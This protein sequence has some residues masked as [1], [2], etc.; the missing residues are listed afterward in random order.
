M[1][2]LRT[3]MA[4]AAE[5]EEQ[6]AKWLIRLDAGATPEDWARHARWL[7]DSPRHRAAFLRLSRAWSGSNALRKL[8][9]LDCHVD[10]DL[11]APAES[12]RPRV[13]VDWRRVGLAVGASVTLAVV[14]VFAWRN[15]AA[16]DA[17][18]YETKFAT[19]QHVSL[20][21][22]TQ[23]NLNGDSVIRVNFTPTLRD[24]VVERGE[25]LFDV[26]AEARR[27]FRVT[28]GNTV[29]TT[30]TSRFSV[31]RRAA[32]TTEVLVSRGQVVFERAR[33][34]LYFTGS[35]SRFVRTL[36]AG[37]MAS[38][39]NGGIFVRAIGTAAVHRRLAWVD[40][41]VAFLGETLEEAVRE[42]NRY[43]HQQ[44]VILDPAIGQLRVSGRFD[45]TDPDSFVASL[46]KPLGVRANPRPDTIRLISA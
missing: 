15:A 34:P 31:H 28:A 5:I 44:L 21:D 10:P 20:T 40:R 12:R 3:D 43:N 39:D 14:G 24:V 2:M 26:A 42:I 38:A 27:P 41:Q 46:E 18:V 36:W 6:A 23:I 16:P 25:A 1:D 8:R 13:T 45:A 37:T 19:T 4:S 7:A 29:T 17:L 11:L 32:D 30:L 35:G 33:P 9:P 22:G